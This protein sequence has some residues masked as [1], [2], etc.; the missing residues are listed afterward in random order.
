M[1]FGVGKRGGLLGVLL[2]AGGCGDDDGGESSAPY[3]LP[4]G[5]CEFRPCDVATSECQDRLYRLAACASRYEASDPPPVRAISRAEFRSELEAAYAESETDPAEDARLTAMLKALRLLPLD[6]PSIA[7]VSFDTTAT[8]V[9]AYYLPADRE[10]TIIEDAESSAEMRS[11][12]L[13]HEYCHA[14]QDETLGLGALLAA[15]DTTDLELAF[16]SLVEGEAVLTANRAFAERPNASLAEDDYLE[17][18]R[19]AREDLRAVAGDETV[20]YDGPYVSFP[21]IHGAYFVAEQAFAGGDSALANLYAERPT[22]S[23]AIARPEVL[24]DPVPSAAFEVIPP[25]DWTLAFSDVMG[26]WMLTMFELRARAG[27]ELVDAPTSDWAGDTFLA[28]TGP[29][30]EDAAFVWR[31]VQ[32]SEGSSV[33]LQLASD[34]GTW[35]VRQEADGYTLVWA[36]EPE[37]LA[38]WEAAVFGE[39]EDR[40]RPLGTIASGTARRLPRRFREA[41]SETW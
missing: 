23:W 3:D 24:G 17:Q 28:F 19:R 5:P 18:Y 31:V 21:Y 13:V 41:L 10:I 29:A 32:A 16:R 22:T 20:P 39:S 36:T 6:A 35:S 9:L 1:R 4:P 33:G 25:S 40:A 37:H 7:E 15:S 27:F 30:P 8:G 14:L 12:T 26:A 34:V 2:L 38:V 11:Y